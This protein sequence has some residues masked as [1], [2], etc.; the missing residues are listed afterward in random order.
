MYPVALSNESPVGSAGEIDQ[1]VAAPPE[2]VIVSGPF[3]PVTGVATVSD[4]VVGVRVSDGTPRIVIV[5]RT[6]EAAEKIESPFW[7]AAMVHVPLLTA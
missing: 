6:V 2:F 5:C 4:K 1:N 7:F 3:A